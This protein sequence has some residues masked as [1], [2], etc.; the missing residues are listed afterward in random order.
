MLNPHLYPC[1]IKCLT[2]SYVCYYCSESQKVAGETTTASAATS[3]SDSA[4]KRI[5]DRECTFRNRTS[6]LNA[7][8]KTFENVLK[9][10]DL[11]NAETKEK[12]EKASKATLLA[13]TN[14]VRKEQLPLSRLVKDKIPGALFSAMVWVTAD[15][16]HT[17]YSLTCI[18]L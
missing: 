5:L 4:I 6:V 1:T 7:N 13:P 14:N 10:I 15:M 18:F 16:I 3:A 2:C 9:L 8:K 17:G 12:I 11:V